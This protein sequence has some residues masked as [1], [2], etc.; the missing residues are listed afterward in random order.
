MN[1]VYCARRYRPSQCYGGI[2]ACCAAIQFTVEA[3]T[4]RWWFLCEPK[5]VGASVTILCCFTF[6]GFNS[7]HQFE[8]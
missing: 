6:Y 5:H 8:Q 4:Q 7:V 1:M 3:E 2:S